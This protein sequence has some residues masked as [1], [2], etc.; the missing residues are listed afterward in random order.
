MSSSIKMS[1]ITKNNKNWEDVL[2]RFDIEDQNA[3]GLLADQAED[4]TSQNVNSSSFTSRWATRTVL[5]VGCT[6]M[7]GNIPLQSHLPSNPTELP[8]LTLNSPEP[9]VQT[10]EPLK[11]QSAS[12]SKAPTPVVKASETVTETAQLASVNEGIQT[13]VLPKQALAT[14]A[15]YELINTKSTWNTY[16]VKHS[17]SQATI[18]SQI[19]QPSILQ[20]LKKVDSIAE[21]LKEM[22]TGT[23]VRAKSDQGKL[24]QLVFS[25]DYEKSFVIEPTES[26]SFEGSWQKKQFEVRQ[27]RATFSVKKNLFKDAEKAEVP[28]NITRQIVKVFDWDVDF[29]KNANIGDQITVVF[30]SIYHNGDEVGSL[31]LIAAELVDKGEVLRSIRHTTAR[32]LTDYFTP[33]GREMKRAFLR[34]PLARAKVSSHFNPNR[35]HPVLKILR[36]HKGTD[37]AA[38]VGTPIIATGDGEVKSVGTKGGYG[39]TI[40]LK[41]R[42]GYTTLYSHLS[43]FK[44]G[45]K[46][47]QVIAQGDVIGYVGSSGLATGPNLHYEFRK[48]DKPVNP[49]TVKLPNSLSLTKK[50]LASFNVDAINMRLQLK[51]L[52]RFA[53]ENVDI[54]SATGG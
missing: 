6:F 2:T 43:K 11:V 19:K 16:T 18:F 23:I 32:G 35:L 49:I 12:I 9:E 52:H 20:E 1:S 54:N 15:G 13:L 33:E 31:N 4:A 45:L 26:G 51:V 48:N 10:S 5:L 30:E 39:K 14:H 46:A 22:K 17:D 25:P 50:E 27:A 38:R 53:K 34:M 21:A 24:E 36:P 42:E 29:T 8:E 3:S 37:F 28:K 47:G 40:V 44:D 7:L 41:H